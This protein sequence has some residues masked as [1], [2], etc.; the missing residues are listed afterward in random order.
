[1]HQKAPLNEARGGRA[2]IEGGNFVGACQKGPI[3]IGKAF[4]ILARQEPHVCIAV[5]FCQA[6]ADTGNCGRGG[7]DAGDNRPC[8]LLR[9]TGVQFFV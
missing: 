2:H 4:D 8:N 6:L 9:I 3:V 5:P 7:G 1:M